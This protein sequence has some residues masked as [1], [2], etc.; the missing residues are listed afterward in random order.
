MVPPSTP[1]AA[2]TV[3]HAPVRLA[4]PLLAATA[5]GHALHLLELLRGANLLARL[6]H[7][8]QAP[9][10][11]WCFYSADGLPL[12]PAEKALGPQLAPLAQEGHFHGAPTHWLLAP[13]HTA[14]IPA[15][16]GV[17][18]AHG[19]LVRRLALGL[20]Q[21]EQVLTLGSGAW[22][23]AA[24][25]RLGGAQ[26]ALPWYY[27][28]GFCNDHPDIGVAVGQPHCCTGPWM[29]AAMPQQATA[30]AVALAAQGL[31]HDLTQA[32]E[33][34]TRPDP[35]REQAAFEAQQARQ[36]RPTRDSTLAR[37]IAF[38]EKHL[39]QPYAL[40]AVAQAAAVSPRT[41]LRH[42]RE[43][44]GHSPLD[45]LH[46]L[47]CARARVLLE[48][49]LDGIPSIAQACGYQDPAAFRRIF[50]RHTGLTPQA[51]RQRQSLRAPRQR[52]RV[53]PRNRSGPLVHTEKF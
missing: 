53:D 36:I 29:S 26:V 5:L 22:L 3:S 46:A 24:T 32:L 34:A 41:L 11:G 30:L 31:G 49:T 45:H 12:A 6:R 7:G 38:L 40:D 9:Q 42:F 48:I 16:R 17:V 23:A 15:I 51:Y 4:V 47:R 19:A 13:L 44:L 37:A 33:A 14:D 50:Q 1:L 25:G 35:L 21:G 2:L 20:D 39:E 28:A 27:I 43:G 10:I 18:A 52:W 8:P